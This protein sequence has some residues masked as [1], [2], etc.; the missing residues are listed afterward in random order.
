ME[1]AIYSTVA[2]SYGIKVFILKCTGEK[3]SELARL[4]DESATASLF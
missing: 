3:V 1:M 4:K 2:L